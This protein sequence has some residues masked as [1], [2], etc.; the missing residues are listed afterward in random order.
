M[1]SREKTLEPVAMDN[2]MMVIAGY[3]IVPLKL[4]KKFGYPRGTGPLATS[5]GCRFMQ[6]R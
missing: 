5:A 2:Q 1:S 4:E 6:C 3:Q